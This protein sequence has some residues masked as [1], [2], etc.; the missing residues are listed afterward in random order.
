MRA[1]FHPDSIEFEDYPFASASVA[2]GKRLPHDLIRDVDVSAAPPEIRT[3]QGE[4]LF[5]SAEQREEFQAAVRAAG[6]PE[7]RRYDVWADL[8]EPYLDTEFTL[9]EQRET[10]ARLQECGYVETEVNRI[11]H[12]VAR[13]MLNYNFSLW[14]WVYLGLFDVLLAMRPRLTLAA[15]IDPRVKRFE[16]F[17]QD[18]MVIAEQG[19]R[20]PADTR[21]SHE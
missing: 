11:R 10:L 16:R 20:K 8:L 12:R 4:T 2:S 21:S 3:Q 15:W 18:A 17:Y 13:P 1:I 7:V 6:I 14:E 9:E 5:V 19:R